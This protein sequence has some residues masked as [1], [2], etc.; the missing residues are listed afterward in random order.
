[1][2]N[3]TWI[4]SQPSKTLGGGDGAP[5]AGV[6]VVAGGE[7]AQ[8]RQQCG[9][10]T[11]EDRSGARRTGEDRAEPGETIPVRRARLGVFCGVANPDAEVADGDAEDVGARGFSGAGGGSGDTK[12]AKAKRRR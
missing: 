11:G 1:M 12:K 6:F 10:V 3:R 7:R 4:E 2:S 8:D 9:G 5:V